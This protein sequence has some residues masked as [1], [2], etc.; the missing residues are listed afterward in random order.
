MSSSQIQSEAP[1]ES[2]VWGSFTPSAWDAAH[3]SMIVSRY[4]MPFD[5]D[6]AISGH[7]LNWWQ[8]NHPDWILYA[9]DQNGN[10]THYVARD[11]GFP[12]VLLDI[13]NPQVIQ[14]QI[15]QEVGPYM[16]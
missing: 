2:L 6:Y 10:P 11:D 13:H 15:S 16:I 7:D 5:D 8:Q 12:N 3:P 9:C 14:Y 1:Y 4:L